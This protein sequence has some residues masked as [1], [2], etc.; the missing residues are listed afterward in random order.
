MAGRAAVDRVSPSSAAMLSTGM[1]TSTKHHEG[2]PGS[3]RPT[4]P[5]APTSTATSTEAAT[6]YQ[7]GVLP[8]NN[9]GDPLSRGRTSSNTSISAS[10]RLSQLLGHRPSSS[11]RGSTPSVQDALSPMPFQMDLSPSNTIPTHDHDADARGA[12]GGPSEQM[13]QQESF[14]TS[15]SGMAGSTIETLRSKWTASRGS[16]SLGPTPKLSSPSIG[17]TAS[18]LLRSVPPRPNPPSK[19][20]RA[21]PL[22]MDGQC[23]PLPS[24]EPL[25]ASPQ[26]APVDHSSDVEVC[27]AAMRLYLDSNQIWLSPGPH[28]RNDF[29]RRSPLKIQK[30][31]TSPCFLEKV[32]FRI[33]RTHPPLCRTLLVSLASPAT[34]WK[35][36]RPPTTP[37]TQSHLPNLKR[38]HRYAE[39]SPILFLRNRLPHL[40]RWL[41]LVPLQLEFK[42]SL[43][44]PP[45][46]PL[47]PNPFFHLSNPKAAASLRGALADTGPRKANNLRPLGQLRPRSPHPSAPADATTEGS[48]FRPISVEDDQSTVESSDPR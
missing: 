13:F 34:L 33:Q 8:C 5:K 21:G 42:T 23:I 38:R 37:R 31:Q 30:R 16:C 15:L 28:F 11:G 36:P 7:S 6:P 46:P 1:T 14:P 26:S 18:S 24:S 2:I 4:S 3:V 29:L 19:Q 20:Q 40:P 32:D 41:H 12:N 27:R 44:N 45:P 48:S 17:T 9:S 35:P 43:W 10:A 39:R 22:A 25:G 47:P